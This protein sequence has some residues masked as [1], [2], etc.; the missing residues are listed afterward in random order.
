M[1]EQRL[2]KV[3]GRD[4]GVGAPC[5][6]IGEV[7]LSHDG[8]LGLAHAFVD[9][10]A[11]AGAD[12]VKFQTHIAEAEST[13]SEPFRV[14][15]STQ[16]ASR[17][18]YWERMAFKEHEWVGLAEHARERE[19]LFLS[20]PFSD[21]AVD[22]LE[23]VGVPGWKIGSGETGNR[24]LLERV[25]RTRLPVIL[26]SGLSSFAELD[27]AA[28]LIRSVGAPLVVLQCNHRLSVSARAGRT[29]PDRRAPAPLRVPGR[30]LR[31]LRHALRIAGSRDARRRR[32]RDA[33]HAQPFDVRSR[34]VGVAHPGGAPRSRRRHPL[35][36]D[37]SAEPRGEG[38]AGRGARAAATAVHQEPRRADRS[39][40]PGRSSKTLTW[41]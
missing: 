32:R 23:R 37:R 15:F 35:H 2:V 29:Q 5:L 31:P 8:S 17:Y 30:S 11:E 4:V 20:S 9:V 6:I 24:S 1:T 22:L 16:D 19:L 14:P 28:E 27:A 10:I 12:A 3:G 41:R 36:R 18:E 26:S 40:E 34:R 7:A 13:L 38:P 21:A 25:A 39:R 33:R